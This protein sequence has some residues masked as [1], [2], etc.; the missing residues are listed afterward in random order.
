[1]RRIICLTL[2]LL[3]ASSLS[4]TAFAQT[5]QFQG[6]VTDPSQAV[7]VGAEVRIFNQAMR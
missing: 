2:A 5:S 6:R 7:V 1:M 4:L 3:F